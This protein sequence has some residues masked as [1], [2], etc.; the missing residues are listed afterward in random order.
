MTHLNNEKERKKEILFLS[1]IID[2]SPPTLPWFPLVQVRV[3]HLQFPSYAIEPS[4]IHCNVFYGDFQIVSDVLNERTIFRPS[5]NPNRITFCFRR[6]NYT[7]INRPS[8]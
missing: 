4:Q 6:T 7:F 3:I 1:M 5:P 8:G 2:T